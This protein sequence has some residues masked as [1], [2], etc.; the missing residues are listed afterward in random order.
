MLLKQNELNELV[1]NFMN[2]N[3]RLI[4]TTHSPYVLTALDN[5]IQAHNTF[6]K[7][8]EEREKIS[9]VISEEKWVAINNVSAYYL[10]DGEATDIIDYELD[11]IGANKIDDVSEL[12]SLIYDKLLKIMFDNE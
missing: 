8:P 6:D 11:A 10:K 12:H 1:E 2:Q 4:I 9:S 7:K 3:D 5:L